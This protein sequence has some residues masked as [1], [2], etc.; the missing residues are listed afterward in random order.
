MDGQAAGWNTHPLVDNLQERFDNVC[1][2]RFP[3]LHQDLF[4][5]KSFQI[6]SFK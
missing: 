4:A 5:A 1:V 6:R 3:D 2:I